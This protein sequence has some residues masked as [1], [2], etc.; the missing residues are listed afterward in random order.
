MSNMNDKQ[1]AYEYIDKHADAFIGVSDRIW[2]YA[3]LSL[4]EFRSAA[5]YCDFLEQNGFTV[6]RNL[7]GVPT[8]FSGSYGA[9]RPVIGILGEFDALSGLSQEGGAAEQRSAGGDTGHGCNHNLLG[10]GSLAAAG[11]RG[12]LAG[13]GRCHHLAP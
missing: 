2:D 1:T 7:C 4:K 13:A 5:L 12:R 10:A 11:A 8:A 3:E 9:G 6:E